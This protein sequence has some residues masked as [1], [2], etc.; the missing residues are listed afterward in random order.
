LSSGVPGRSAVRVSHS[1]IQP[2]S[3]NLLGIRTN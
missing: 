2:K 1:G 3:G